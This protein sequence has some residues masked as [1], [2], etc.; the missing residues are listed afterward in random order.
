M[1]SSKDDRPEKYATSGRTSHPN[2]D[3]LLCG[4]CQ[5]TGSKINSQLFCPPTPTKVSYPM[6]HSDKLIV[7]FYPCSSN[8]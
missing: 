3:C 1:L 4:I 2:S 6:Y 7:H 8:S 5:M